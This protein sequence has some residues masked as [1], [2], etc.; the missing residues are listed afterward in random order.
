[1]A[2]KLRLLHHVCARASSSSNTTAFQNT[3]VF[4]LGYIIG[5]PVMSWRTPLWINLGTAA[6]HITIHSWVG[7]CAHVAPCELLPEATF[8]D[9]GRL[10]ILQLLGAVARVRL[11]DLSHPPV[12]TIR[13][14]MHPR[15]LILSVYMAAFEAGSQRKVRVLLPKIS[16]QRKTSR[17][18][19]QHLFCTRG[20][21]SLESCRCT[22]VS[23]IAYFRKLDTSSGP[24][25]RRN[26][27]ASAAGE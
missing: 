4:R 18:V 2:A 8:Q 5:A 19:M 27:C 13:T 21:M 10:V 12:P 9:A 23:A 22:R 17:M 6:G 3:L 15:R 1:M 11:P 25:A 14:T 26:S 7:T 24:C 16:A 20:V